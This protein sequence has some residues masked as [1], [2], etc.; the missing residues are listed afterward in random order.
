MR[1]ENVWEMYA[2][3]HLGTVIEAFDDIEALDMIHTA[4]FE[5]AVDVGVPRQLL[6]QKMEDVNYS[7]ARKHRLDERDVAFLTRRS[8]EQFDKR[9]AVDI[10]RSQIL[11]IAGLIDQQRGTSG[12]A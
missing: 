3:G 9:V 5:N 6:S 7:L 10:L 12:T 1:H 4:M 2:S 11:A 8:M